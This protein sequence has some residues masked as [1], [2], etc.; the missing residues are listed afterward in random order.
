MNGVVMR[1][2][3]TTTIVGPI[4]L[5]ILTIWIWF[6]FGT[7]AHAWTDNWR[8]T[9]WGWQCS[10]CPYGP[11]RIPRGSVTRPIERIVAGARTVKIA[12]VRITDAGRRA[13]D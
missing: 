2:L 9:P 12:R 11:G 13:R 8:P 6:A 10:R 1:F 5:V 4:V 3:G 7:R